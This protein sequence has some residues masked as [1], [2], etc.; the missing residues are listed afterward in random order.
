MNVFWTPSEDDDNIEIDYEN[1][2]ITGKWDWSDAAAN[3]ARHSEPK[4]DGVYG[5]W[6]APELKIEVVE[7][8]NNGALGIKLRDGE[9]EDELNIFE[10][11]QLNFDN[12]ARVKI[13][14]NITIS[15]AES[16]IVKA[17]ILEGDDIPAGKIAILPPAQMPGT[18]PVTT[19]LFNL[20]HGNLYVQVHTN[21][22]PEPGDIRG[23]ILPART[24][25]DAE[26]NV[27]SGGTG[28]ELFELNAADV[29]GLKIV[30][31]AGRETLI[32][33]GM[34]TSL[35][36]LH[37]EDNDLIIDINQDGSFQTGE[38]LT[39]KDFFAN[40][41]GKVG[42]GYIELVDGISGSEISTSISSSEND[43]LH[44]TSADNVQHGD[45][46]GDIMFGFAGND[47]LYGNRGNDELYGGD[48]DD[49]L[50]GG[51][52]ND[53][54]IGGKGD[55]SM[56]GDKGNDLLESNE[57]DDLLNGAQGDDTLT[58]GEGS[59]RFV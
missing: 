12:G 21:Q 37:R 16:S 19:S 51:K 57:G 30:E 55:D 18:T 58:G 49:L 32:L 10:G 28:N 33:E 25:A 13:T 56:F 46:G 8:Y 26:G 41:V 5:D 54:V 7:A 24:L 11:T 45:S 59:D 31:S 14:E 39:L 35:S 20:F 36:N 22:N 42:K 1:E 6:K 15:K 40:E 4:S 23:Q 29:G 43:L 50:H 53:S 48:G 52:D 38:D 47:K 44:G 27:L 2:R 9:P 17:N 34:E 3:F